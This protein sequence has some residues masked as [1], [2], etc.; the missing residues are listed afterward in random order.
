[1]ARP[2]AP[3]SLRHRRRGIALVEVVITI[4]VISVAM[5]GLLGLMAESQRRGADSFVQVRA[6]ELGQ[7]LLEEILSRTRYA[8]CSGGARPDWDG[9]DCFNGLDETPPRAPDGTVLSTY[10]DY[11]IRATVASSTLQ[12]RAAKRITVI[13]TTPQNEDFPFASWRTEF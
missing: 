11:R 3:D 12:G 13:V 7:A 5:V 2:S 9:I 4:V 10:A 1:M 8:G 6:A